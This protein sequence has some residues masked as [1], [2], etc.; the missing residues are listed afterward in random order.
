[1]RARSCCRVSG[2]GE[3]EE[4]E[5]TVSPFEE[6][7]SGIGY[8]FGVFIQQEKWISNYGFV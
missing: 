3:E 4:E 2:V 5:G 1:M 7:Q 8:G 6:E